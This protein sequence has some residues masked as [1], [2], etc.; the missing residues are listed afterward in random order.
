VVKSDVRILA[1]TNIDIPEALATKRL[2]EDLYYRLNAFTLHLPPLRE[3]KEEIPILLKQFMSRMAERYARPPLPL[4]PSLLQ[5]CQ[6]HP[7]PGNLRELNNFLKRYLILGDENLAVSELQ[8]RNDGTGGASGEGSSKTA[9]GAGGLKSLARNAKDG[10]EAEAITRALEQT[11]W[12]RKQAAA[13]LQISYKAL[14]YKIRQY[15]IA[16]TKSHHKLSA[17]A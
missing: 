13:M 17:G 15:G 5:A 6:D 14:L 7:W 9:N 4:S 2:R 11:N 12:N 8:P 10:A 3:R 16:E 1:A